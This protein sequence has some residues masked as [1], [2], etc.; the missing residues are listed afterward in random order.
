MLGR[1]K[2]YHEVEWAWGTD[3]DENDAS[4]VTLAA[5]TG[6]R[7]AIAEIFAGYDD[8]PAAVKVLTVTDGTTTLSFPIING[9][10]RHFVFDR[11]FLGAEGAAVTV[12]LPAGG[13]G[14][15]GYLNVMYG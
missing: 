1:L 6:V 13:A 15:T 9:E 14:I 2:E 4:T 5:A 10:T 7:H 8:I 3:S 12:T 11:G